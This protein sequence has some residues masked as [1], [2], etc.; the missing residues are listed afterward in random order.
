MAEKKDKK[1]KKS[2]KK[3]ATVLKPFIINIDS[4]MKDPAVLGRK[5]TT[6]AFITENINV[7]KE[8]LDEAEEITGV[9]FNGDRAA[10]NHAYVICE[11]YTF[12]GVLHFFAMWKDRIMVRERSLCAEIYARA[13]LETES[14]KEEEALEAE[15]PDD[16]NSADL[17]PDA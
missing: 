2:K 9:S 7:I 4:V 5:K 10:L 3:K 1:K 15:M 12:F 8:M 16:E 13:E 14:D 17:S 11:K 6:K